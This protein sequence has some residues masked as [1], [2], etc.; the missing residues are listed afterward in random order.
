MVALLMN[1]LG[2]PGPNFIIQYG[3][4]M[5]RDA[6]SLKSTRD[7]DATLLVQLICR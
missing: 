7:V 1:W 4:I 6:L 3:S 2:E 5:D